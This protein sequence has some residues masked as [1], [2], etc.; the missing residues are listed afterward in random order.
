MAFPA[1]TQ[2][3]LSLVSTFEEGHPLLLTYGAA[4]W[5]WTLLKNP[6]LSKYLYHYLYTHLVVKAYLLVTIRVNI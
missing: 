6:A 5:G 4:C 2:P 3:L 1:S